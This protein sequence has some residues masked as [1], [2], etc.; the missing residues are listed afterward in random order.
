MFLDAISSVYGGL[1][2]GMHTGMLNKISAMI[3]LNGE[4]G[5]F[6][7]TLQLTAV[8]V[9]CYVHTRLILLLDVAHV[10]VLRVPVLW[11]LQNFTSLGAEAVGLAMM[12][13]NICAG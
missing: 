12:I 1:T 11:A 3:I 7:C 9:L 4:T 8:G 5:Q 6:C 2:T 13:S 10:F